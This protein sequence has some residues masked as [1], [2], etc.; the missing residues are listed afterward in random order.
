M[1]NWFKEIL[2]LF[3]RL[4]LFEI[5]FVLTVFAG[6]F[7]IGSIKMSIVVK[8]FLIVTWMIIVWRIAGRRILHER[9]KCTA[10]NWE[11]K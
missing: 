3:R 8:V 7:V 5:V 9:K 10:E 6:A 1:R 11:Q 4:F 2:L